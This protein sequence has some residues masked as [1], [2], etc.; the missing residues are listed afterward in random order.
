MAARYVQLGWAPVPIPPR[1]KGAVRK[2]WTDLRLKEAD[3]PAHFS[4]DSNIGMLTG[5]ASGGLVDVDL[6]CDE[7]VALGP[8][9][10]PPTP[11]WSGR[12]TRPQSHAWYVISD[13]IP[14]ARKFSDT[15]G[16]TVLVELRTNRLN[17]LVPPSIHPEGDL[18]QWAGELSP[19]TVDAK[20]LRRAVARLAGAALVCRHWPRLSGSRNDIANALIGMLLRAG[21]SIESTEHFIGEVTA[22]AGDEETRA[23]VANVKATAKRLDRDGRATGAP[24]LAK[25]LGQ[26]VVDC[27]RQWL[28]IRGDTA[29]I[30]SNAYSSQ[31]A[32][33]PPPLDTAALHGI[34]GDFVRIVEPHSE[35]DPAAIL[36]QFL[37]AAGNYIGR[38]PRFMVESDAHHV[39]LFAV[40]VGKSSK[41]RKGTSWGRVS[42]VLKGIDER[43]V[44]DNLVKGLSSGEGLIWA[45][46]DETKRLHHVK[47]KG[48]IVE[49]QEIVDDPG[50]SDKRL[51]VLEAEFASPLKVAAREGNTLSPTI[52]SAWDDG[53]L[54]IL[55]KNSPARATDAHISIL[56]HITKDEVLRYLNCTEMSNGF[57]NRFLW[58]CAKRS[59]LLPEGGFL[60]DRELGPLRHRLRGILTTAQD[61]GKLKRTAETSELWREAYAR[62]SA[63]RVGLLGSITSRAEALV[64]RLSCLYALLDGSD[65]VEPA[66]LR[67]ALAVWGYAEASAT[68]IFGDALGDPVA[69][70]ILTTLR[71]TPDGLRRSEIA[72]LFGRNKPS[73]TIDSALRTLLHNRFIRRT[74]EKT[75]GRPAERFFAVQPYAINAV[76]AK[77]PPEDDPYRVNRV[78]R[79]TDTVEDPSSE[80]QPEEPE[81]APTEAPRSQPQPCFACK[82]TR[83]WR[84]QWGHVLCSR[85][86]PPD[87]R[88]VVEW[89]E[90]GPDA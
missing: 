38:S 19:A 52:R 42:G 8:R 84:T 75:D 70:K 27:L 29:L 3:L 49:T 41:G 22:A 23:R 44:T 40:V 32:E 80:P 73:A 35:A 53:N 15:N 20:T 88:N 39:N 74:K 14:A 13:E 56:G 68:Y 85:C 25:H 72:D 24:A 12:T 69:D 48:R 81:G 2:G 55:T 26:S 57:A 43:W 78:Y 86:H 18:Y 17:T 87:P 83:F 82:S 10:L 54:R 64:T 65:R 1:S 58:I 61:I 66:H 89:I 37:V 62:L 9:F 63:E 59:K 11:M 21:W 51:L 45:V 34:A 30:A 6:D 5:E 90:S 50:V 46:R 67:A 79:V 31:S 71:E 28:H 33:W 16:K 7:A 60:S 36:I 47:E 4:H 76:Y 77:S